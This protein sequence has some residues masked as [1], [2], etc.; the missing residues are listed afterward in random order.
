MTF[1]GSL[2]LSSVAIATDHIFNPD[3][4][5]YLR[6]AYA[7]LEGDEPPFHYSEWPFYDVLIGITSLITTLKPLHAAYLLN[8]LMQASA[9]VA[10]LR[11]FSLVQGSGKKTYWPAIVTVFLISGF[12]NSRD[13]IIRDH[14]YILFSLT[15]LIFLIQFLR[16]PSKRNLILTL[17]TLTLAFLFRVEGIVLLSAA[18]ILGLVYSGVGRSGMARA[19]LLALPCLLG[20]ASISLAFFSGVIPGE[21]MDQ[22]WHQ[23][24]QIIFAGEYT[25]A[26]LALQSSVLW[27]QSSLSDG[28]WF[29]AGGSI[30]LIIQTIISCLSAFGI[31]ALCAGFIVRRRNPK[32]WNPERR[33]IFCVILLCALYLTIYVSLYRFCATRYVFLIS[34]MLAIFASENIKIIFS[35]KDFHKINKPLLFGTIILALFNINHSGILRSDGKEFIIEASDKISLE[36]KNY[37]FLY[38]NHYYIAY[39]SRFKSKYYR[40]ITSD[41]HRDLEKIHASQLDASILF[42]LYSRSETE[43]IFSEKLMAMG[44]QLVDSYRHRNKS[45]DLYAFKRSP[46]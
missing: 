23:F 20:L 37:E 3:G 42:A 38:T 27:S 22:L 21:R 14:G 6:G 43:K 26:A 28:Y 41:T 34:L 16:T 7:F 5:R 4:M 12:N 45:L 36:S 25:N 15:G 35:E 13:E 17:F 19:S 9:C 10:F 31:I 39:S 32:P 18:P 46:D 44:F 11:L 40:G 33:L 8:A 29:L 2:L 1:A 24:N 30:A